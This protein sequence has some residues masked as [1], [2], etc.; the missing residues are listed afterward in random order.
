MCT[1]K[2]IDNRIIALARY[3]FAHEKQQFWPPC[4]LFFTG[5]FLISL[6]HAEYPLPSQ[7]ILAFF[8]I[9][10]FIQTLSLMQSLEEDFNDGTFAY[11]ISEGF[12]IH[13]Y[14]LSRLLVTV[15]TF[16]FPILSCQAVGLALMNIDM[17]ALLGLGFNHFHCV[18]GLLGVQLTLCMTTNFENKMT[19]LFI[20]IPFWIP[21]FLYLVGQPVDK[22]P[23]SP[24][25][26]LALLSA[27]LTLLLI[28]NAFRWRGG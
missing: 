23:L 26:G 22:I 9:W 7:G 14:A 15:A 16:S 28:Q 25:I 18:S 13:A 27:G 19:H 8:A 12:S 4:V 1:A 24:L 20:F 11:L 5:I 10:S 6:V 17:S 3:L 2:M 21:S